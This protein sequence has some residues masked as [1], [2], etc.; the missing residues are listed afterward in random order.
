RLQDGERLASFD[1]VARLAEQPDEQSRHGRLQ[2]AAG[3]TSSA[4]PCHRCQA[5][6]RLVDDLGAVVHAGDAQR[7]VV[8]GRPGQKP[9]AAVFT[10]QPVERAVDDPDLYGPLFTTVHAYGPA[11]VFDAAQLD[12]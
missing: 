1:D 12:A 11:I 3:V 5:G 4:T 6:T 9:H 8:V 2:L 7:D 10:P